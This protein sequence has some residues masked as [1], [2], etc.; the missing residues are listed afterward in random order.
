MALLLLIIVGA[1]AGWFASIVARTEAVG[2]ILRQMGIGLVV[3]LIA[4]LLMNSGT[5]LGGLSL[6]ALGTATGAAIAALVLYHLFFTRRSD[7]VDA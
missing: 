5:M 6:I 2:A 3:S 4:G 1:S 7:R